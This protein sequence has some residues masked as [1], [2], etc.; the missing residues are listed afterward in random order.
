MVF[1]AFFNSYPVKPVIE[2]LTSGP[3][4]P[5]I[6]LTDYDDNPIY[7]G[8]YV[9]IE[10][11][12]PFTELVLTGKASDTKDG[13]INVSSLTSE[14]DVT[15]RY[16]TITPRE[17]SATDSDGNSN[18]ITINFT[19][20]DTNDPVFSSIN[21]SYVNSTGVATFTGNMSEECTVNL[22]SGS[23]TGTF[24]DTDTSTSGSSNTFSLTTSSVV[25]YYYLTAYDGVNTTN[26]PAIER[27]MS[28]DM[29][30][31]HSYNSSTNLSRV[32][33]SYT[34]I[35]N[36]GAYNF[37]IQLSTNS[38]FTNI[39]DTRSLTSG[40]TS[41]TTNWTTVSGSSYLRTYYARISADAFVSST[42]TGTITAGGKANPNG[43]AIFTMY[44][45]A[46]TTCEIHQVAGQFR[47]ITQPSGYSIN[48][49]TKAYG[50]LFDNPFQYGSHYH[51][52]NGNNIG[53]MNFKYNGAY[54]ST[55]TI[56][57]EENDRPS[58]RITALTARY[59][60]NVVVTY[61]RTSESKV[62]NNGRTRWR[63]YYSGTITWANA[64]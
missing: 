9:S 35:R 33:A 6:N 41:S 30:L 18:T 51:R 3:E 59:N 34:T 16:G 48:P 15:E 49:S 2:V 57:T 63:A 62:T 5:I 19:I 52:F 23:H 8:S 12:A 56:F 45:S 26:Y 43:N 13:T 40:T 38:G 27:P 7:D 55:V 4:Q 39:V 32:R 29:S 11:Y 53:F 21:P 37:T 20:D 54:T 17:F 64:P 31:Q 61:T 46:S 36:L 10:R 60:G 22:Y 28:F 25:R 58:Q 44:I 1:T 47:N 42:A 14:P 50:F 24:L